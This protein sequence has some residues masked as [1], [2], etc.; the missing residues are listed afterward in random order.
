MVSNSPTEIMIS[1][2]AAW[3]NDI[4]HFRRRWS[5]SRSS[6]SNWLI[7]SQA[8]ATSETKVTERDQ[9]THTVCVAPHRLKD[10]SPQKS[11]KIRFKNVQDFFAL[12]FR[13]LI[14]WAALLNRPVWVFL[15]NVTKILCREPSHCIYRLHGNS[16]DAGV[17]LLGTRPLVRNG[18]ASLRREISKNFILGSAKHAPAKQLTKVT[19]PPKKSMMPECLSAQHS[20]SSHCGSSRRPIMPELPSCTNSVADTGCV[21]KS[22]LASVPSLAAMPNPSPQHPAE[23]V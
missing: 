6:S 18:L 9:A 22:F 16:Q 14:F 15:G 10:K 11:S 1:L 13:R 4:C 23:C 19:W 3:L 17:P 2:D 7:F 20:A 12:F 8:Y 21:S 5:D